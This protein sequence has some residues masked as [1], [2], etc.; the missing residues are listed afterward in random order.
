MRSGPPPHSSCRVPSL[1]TIDLRPPLQ[2]AAADDILVK[3]ALVTGLVLDNVLRLGFPAASSIWSIQNPWQLDRIWRPL[4]QSGI[5]ARAVAM[6]FCD[7]TVMTKTVAELEDT[8]RVT[9]NTPFPKPATL[10]AGCLVAAGAA[11]Q[12]YERMILADIKGA[13]DDGARLVL[14]PEANAIHT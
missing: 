5:A 12:L 8:D 10:S 4:N 1:E 9:F 11:D 14:V 7:G 6:R 3:G 2:R 13:P